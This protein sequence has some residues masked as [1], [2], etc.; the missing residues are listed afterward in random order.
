VLAS[1]DFHAQMSIQK[2]AIVFGVEAYKVQE[3]MDE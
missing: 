1:T 2:T 3:K